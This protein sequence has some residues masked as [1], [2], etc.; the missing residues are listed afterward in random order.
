MSTTNPLPYNL[1]LYSMN[2]NT[3]NMQILHKYYKILGLGPRRIVFFWMKNYRF[4]SI[5]ARNAPRPT[6]EKWTEM[7]VV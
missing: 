6:V 7:S 5:P 3:D 2:V 1:C 4:H